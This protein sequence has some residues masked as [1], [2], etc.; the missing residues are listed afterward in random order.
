MIGF[1]VL[2]EENG[3]D[4]LRRQSTGCILAKTAYLN[5]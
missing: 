2:K 1:A 4:A 5:T 3:G